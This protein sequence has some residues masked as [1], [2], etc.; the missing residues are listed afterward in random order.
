MTEKEYEMYT[1]SGID[2]YEIDQEFVCREWCQD[3]NDEGGECDN[4][5]NQSITV[6]FDGFSGDD[7][8]CDKCNHTWTRY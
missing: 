8:N 7:V 1:T 5:F 3:C 6:G 2:A 4:V